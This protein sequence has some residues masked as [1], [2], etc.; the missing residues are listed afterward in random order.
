MKN[1]YLC[2]FLT[3]LAGCQAVPNTP[4]QKILGAWQSDVRGFPIVQIYDENTVSISGHDAVAYQ[5]V[6]DS[7]LV[8]SI[9]A[10]NRIVSFP[11]EDEMWQTD[12][13][14][15]SVQQFSRLK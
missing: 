10:S 15:G 4:S 7:L 14:T 11:S 2:V 6:E 13:L 9:G 12:P 1:L 8:D 3:I 5:L